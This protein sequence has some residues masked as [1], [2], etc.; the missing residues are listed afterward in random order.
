MGQRFDDEGESGGTLDRPALTRL[1]ALAQSGGVDRIYITALDRLAR[2]VHDMI[3]LFEE[4]EQAG[5]KV[6]L[7][8]AFNP[9]DGAQAKFMRNV[10][11]VFAEFERDM[12][13]SRIAE[14]R[15]YLK[16]HGR[17]IAGPAPFGYT[18]DLATKQ[19]VPAP[20]EARRVRLIFKR[21]QAGQT[22]AEKRTATRR[23]ET[24]ADPGTPGPR[25]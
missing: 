4:L 1:R 8:Q 7:A 22:P 23:P 24:T 19:L 16:R 2:R 20:K 12:I 18:A 14:T 21:A 25:R 9:P 5:V 6:H 13:A 11:A 3:L 15:A 17:R 10:L